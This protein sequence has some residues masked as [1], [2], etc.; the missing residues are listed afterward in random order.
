MRQ[1]HVRSAAEAAL[2]VY[3]NQNK[4]PSPQETLGEIVSEILQQRV[5][6][7]RMTICSKLLNRIEK[8]TDKDEIDHY[9]GLI[10]LFFDR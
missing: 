6:L 8:S 1:N 10:A 9:N 5:Q 4:L 3:F 2:I 7:S